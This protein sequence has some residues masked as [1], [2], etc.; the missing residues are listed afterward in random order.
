MVDD[1]TSRGLVGACRPLVVSGTSTQ[2]PIL[3][4]DDSPHHKIEG[5]N[6]FIEGNKTDYLDVMVL[7]VD[8]A[9]SH[10][11]FAVCRPLVV[12]GPSTQLPILNR[13]CSAWHAIGTWR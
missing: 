1:A 9:T 8:D 11:L 12:S 3:N 13:E 7:A 6:G 10:G 4:C 5:G 2:L